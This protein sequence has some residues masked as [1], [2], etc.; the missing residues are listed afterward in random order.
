MVGALLCGAC[1]R[2]SVVNN[3]VADGTEDSSETVV[4]FLFG[5]VGD[6]VV[7]VKEHCPN[8]AREVSYYAGPIDLFVSTLSLGFVG[9]RT[10]NIEC[11]PP[12]STAPGS[13]A[14]SSAPP[15]SAPPSSTAPTG[16]AR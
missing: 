2:V 8:G 16:G 6:P 15:G 1:Y 12:G 5:L 9:M 3:S 13:T 10:V 7:D 4:Y 11:A 14:P